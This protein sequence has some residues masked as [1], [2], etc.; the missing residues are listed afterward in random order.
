[1]TT[2]PKSI[3]RGLQFVRAEVGDVKQVIADL[4]QS[5]RD[6]KAHHANELKSLQ[7]G[8]DEL[9]VRQA[10][11][12]MG[13]SAGVTGRRPD[14]PGV[15]RFEA[16]YRRRDPQA[17]EGAKP[18]LADF[19][20]GVAGMKIKSDVVRAALSTGSGPDGG[21]TVPSRLAPSILD[22]MVAESA[23]LNAGARLELIEASS[24]YTTA[25]VD[26]VPTAAWR[27]ERGAVAESDPG[28]R[29]VVAAPKSLACYFRM[30]R[31]LLADG[32][33]LE[34]ALNVVIS[35]AFALAMDRAGLRGSGTNPEPRGIRNTTG[36]H[37]VPHGGAAGAVL[38][39]YGPLFNAVRDILA[40]DHAMPTAAIMSP[41][42]LVNFGQLAD[43]TNQPMRVPALLENLQMLSTTSVPN[44]LVVGGSS[45]CSELYLGDFTQLTYVMRENVSIGLLREA[46][47]TTG[48][49]AFI[50]H[51]R[52]DVAV[53]RPKSFAVV[54][55]VR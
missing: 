36:V 31:E 45:D 9:A 46:F 22:A 6:F 39:N 24:T 25:A 55:G 34:R 16:H 8:I 32:Q 51:A 7:A 37:I 40:A 47:A 53:M 1:M 2:N 43:T 30:S 41:R 48:E 28:F 5:F 54:T 27:L 23:T 3:P 52:V 18:E 29:A 42:S 35:Q 21:F 17:F 14:A 50:A 20:R 49:L 13:G 15:S 26:S 10:G 4:G 19:L 44:D 33:D 12:E 38:T 11:T